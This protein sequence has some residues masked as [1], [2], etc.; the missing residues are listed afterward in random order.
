M[1]KANDR[2]VAME[3]LLKS[4]LR[5][6]TSSAG[7]DVCP[8]AEIIAAWTEGNLPPAKAAKLEAHLA[9][10]GSCQEVLAVFARTEPLPA[11]P[12]SLWRRWRL[13][14]AV[15][16]AAAATV[17]AIYV[18]APD[19]QQTPPMQARRVVASGTPASESPTPGATA[20]TAPPAEKREAFA[21]QDAV[22]TAPG[23]EKETRTRPVEED[24]RL[25]ASRAPESTLRDE[26]SAAR[27]APV[28]RTAEAPV[29]QSRAEALAETIQLNAAAGAA[30]T[31]EIVSPDPL[32]RWR[33]LPIRRLERSTNAGQTWES[34]QLPAN[35]D[36]R[37]VRAPSATSAIVT[38][39]DGR[40]FRTDDQGK[41]W[42]LL[43]R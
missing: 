33:I 16:I 13:Q 18:A 11:A 27:Q 22:N 8:D 20:P 3:S 17:V 21:R 15:P 36:V 2:D 4:K 6:S 10:C 41:T 35:P 39:T 1:T 29:A 37:A 24:R 9:T 7:G 14:W 38:T 28:G 19:D 43:Q 42:N 32:V 31:N 34:V 12:E 26:D 30:A 40:E 5:S 23:L 25:Q